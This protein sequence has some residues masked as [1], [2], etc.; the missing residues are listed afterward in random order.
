MNEYLRCLYTTLDETSANIFIKAMII[1]KTDEGEL[2]YDDR[3]LNEVI[4][5]IPVEVT[6]DKLDFQFAEDDIFFKLE[7][8]PQ[9]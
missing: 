2:L 6:T 8:S 9:L 3:V 4:V 7:S 5:E 1:P